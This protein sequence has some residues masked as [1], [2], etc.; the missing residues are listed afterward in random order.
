MDND[1]KFFVGL[2]AHTDCT[3]IA[4][5]EPRRET[6]CFLDFVGPDLRQALKVLHRYGS[7][8]QVPDT[9]VKARW[10]PPVITD[11]ELD[12]HFYEIRVLWNTVYLERA[13]Q[14]LRESGNP[15]NADLLQFLSPSGW[16]HINLTGVTSGGRT[17]RSTSEN[18]GY[19]GTSKAVD[20]A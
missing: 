15:L 12:R 18:T 8:R 5:C 10:K 6:N 2:D 13:T 7:A 19:G 3:A 1:I 14:T 9:F 20:G 16:E 11:E 17:E 4:V